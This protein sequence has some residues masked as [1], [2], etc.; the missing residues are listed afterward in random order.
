MIAIT[1]RASSKKISSESR[2]MSNVTDDGSASWCEACRS[3]HSAP[4]DKEHHQALRCFA[5]WVD[6]DAQT[7]VEPREFEFS[8]WENGSRETRTITA[9]SYPM[10]CWK[11]GLLQAER[12]RIMGGAPKDFLLE[13][14]ELQACPQP[15][16]VTP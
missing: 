11:L 1:V 13:L 6:H 7:K 15:E 4:R 2:G 10:A 3:Y 12:F 9:D 8:W 5:P 14:G 16:D